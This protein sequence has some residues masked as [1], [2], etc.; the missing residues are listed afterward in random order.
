MLRFAAGEGLRFD[1][2]IM[3]K[4]IF[5][6]LTFASISKLIQTDLSIR[7]ENLTSFS[8]ARG[9][10]DGSLHFSGKTTLR[11]MVG[12]LYTVNSTM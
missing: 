4:K 9:N 11:W 1:I 2:K 6:L 5:V 8:N 3:A 10:L 12:E 7:F